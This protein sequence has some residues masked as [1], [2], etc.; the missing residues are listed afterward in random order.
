MAGRLFHGAITLTLLAWVASTASAQDTLLTQLYGQGVHSFFEGDSEKAHELFSMAIDQ[1][2][3]DPRLFY[4]RGLT[5]H[6]LGRPEEGIEDFKR[7]AE[8][9]AAGEAIQIDVG[10]SLQRVQGPTRL[11][12]EDYRYQARLTAHVD[13]V[14]L[15]Q[16]RYE[17][18]RSDEPRVI[19]RPDAGAAPVELPGVPED[20]PTD[21]FADDPG[22]AAAPAAP[23]DQPAM[24]PAD[25]VDFPEPADPAASEDP[26][27]DPD[28][29]VEVPTD[30]A[31]PADEGPAEPFGAPAAPEDDPFGAPT[32]PAGDLFDVPDAPADPAED[33]FD[34]SDMPAD[35]DLFDTPM[36]DAAEPE[37]ADVDPFGGP[38]ADGDPFG[39]P[40]PAAPAADPSGGAPMA[41]DAAP[42]ADPFGAPA[43]DPFGGPAPE[44]ADPTDELDPDADADP[45][46]DAPMAPDAAPAADPF[47]APAGDP[48][49]APAPPAPG[50]LQPGAAGAPPAPGALQ[51]GAAGA[52]PA[53]GA[54]QPGAAGAPP[55]PGAL[56]PGAA[57]APPAPGA[58]QP[59]AAGAPPAPG[60]LQPGAAGAPPAPGAS[61]LGAPATP[62]AAPA[63]EQADPFAD[64]P[65]EEQPDDDDPFGF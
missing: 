5:Y 43:G 17:E 11:V 37:P 3:R 21:P 55:A 50:A 41:P 39:A 54:L 58:L 20:D 35:V 63:G 8:L 23:D 32:I 24:E 13:D 46:G 9:E 7:G 45:F 42:A 16:R 29:P 62:P 59:G 2:S 48:F 57:G 12:L 14:Q 1:G 26:F 27:A 33:L 34:A 40:A 30:D 28:E 18:F 44:P 25:E 15:R 6:R 10:A 60:A 4:F 64:D 31:A 51:P 65:E 56:Q 52:P 22:A 53:P 49:G 38:P 36:E 19:R 47:G 61:P